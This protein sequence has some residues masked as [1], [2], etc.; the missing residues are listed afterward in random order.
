MKNILFILILSG[1][2]AVAFSQDLIV[3]TGGDSIHCA[4]TKVKPDFIYFTFRYDG[5]YRSTLLPRSQVQYYR[6]GYYQFAEVPKDKL[7]GAADF[8]RFS[9]G[10]GGGFSYLTGRVSDNIPPDLRDYIKQLKSGYHINADFTFFII[11][12]LGVG[13]KYSMF[14]TQNDVGIYVEDS[15]GQIITGMLEDDMTIHFVGPTFFTRGSFKEEKAH[16][17]FGI[18]AGYL[19]YKNEAQFIDA[20]TLT[21]NTF[22]MSF[23]LGMDFRLASRLYMSVAF[24]YMIGTITQYEYDDGVIKETIKLNKDEYEN[25]SRL[26]LSVGLRFYR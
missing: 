6:E 12:Y 24:S 18:G 1:C 5:E 23:D 9:F 7:V 22:G 13:A 21:S 25:I 3:T 16:F 4:I 26:D 14:K 20:F 8:T 11:E 15:S 10:I 2:S 19:R 17:L